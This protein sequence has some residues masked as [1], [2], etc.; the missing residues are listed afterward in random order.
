MKITP[1]TI[2]WR[3]G[4]FRDNL[5]VGLDPHSA[6]DAAIDSVRILA[7][8]DRSLWI[9]EPIAHVERLFRSAR[10]MGFEIDITRDELLSVLKAIR[11]QVSSDYYVKITAT[12]D[13]LSVVAEPSVLNY[14]LT[15]VFLNVSMTP[16]GYPNVDLT[17][18][19]ARNLRDTDSLL[20]D[21]HGL[22]VGSGQA[23]LG[24]VD[25]GRII[26]PDSP[27]S[28]LKGITASVL[29]RAIS[30]RPFNDTLAI[31]MLSYPITLAEVVT[32]EE[33]FLIS[34][35]QGIQPVGRIGIHEKPLHRNSMTSKL[36]D[37]FHSVIRRKVNDNSIRFS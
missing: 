9:L 21:N 20:L 11:D 25:K 5:Q 24:I 37:L 12:P 31:P 15:P 1:P 3:N 4:S 23:N 16:R 19:T 36:N 6:Q 29:M 8:H 30:S 10:I 13:S 18:K 17:A 35:K 14:Q 26:F 34:T 2:F 22:V 28:V 33:V 27:G 7:A 32:A